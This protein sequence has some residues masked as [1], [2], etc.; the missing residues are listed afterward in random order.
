[1]GVLQLQVAQV[2]LDLREVDRLG[3]AQATLDQVV[4]GFGVQRL[5]LPEHGPAQA[6][7]GAGDDHAVDVAAQLA[8]RRLE[9]ELS[10]VGALGAKVEARAA[11]PADGERLE[12]VAG[13]E[14]AQDR[15]IEIP[16]LILGRMGHLVDE[17]ARAGLADPAA[18]EIVAL[19]LP[20]IACD[21]RRIDQGIDPIGHA[22]RVADAA[23]DE[24][25]AVVEIDSHAP[26]Q[27][28]IGSS[29]GSRAAAWRCIDS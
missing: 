6:D 23:I 9:P 16:S 8:A 14:D 29:S 12:L 25:G 15:A 2:E 24:A 1:E 20:P 19:L 13:V 17:L 4:P 11:Q 22:D 18:A 28:G 10:A 7:I 5:V 3:G 21:L 26:P 27:K